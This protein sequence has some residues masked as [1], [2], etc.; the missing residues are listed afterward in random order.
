MVKSREAL[1]SWALGISFSVG[2]ILLGIIWFCLKTGEPWKMVGFLLG[3]L[4]SIPSKTYTHPSDMGTLGPH[5]RCLASGAKF[6]F[7][8]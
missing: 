8:P 1:G 4:Y 2:T 3:F 5:G 6:V 7:L